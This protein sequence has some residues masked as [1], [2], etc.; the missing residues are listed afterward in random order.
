MAGRGLKFRAP[1]G[2]LGVQMG[3]SSAESLGL[4]MGSP[5]RGWSPVSGYFQN[6]QSDLIWQV[7]LKGLPDHSQGGSS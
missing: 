7:Y 5:G 3:M 1:S 2:C 4:L 6:L